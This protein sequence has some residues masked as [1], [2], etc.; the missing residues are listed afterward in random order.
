VTLEEACA[1][2]EK[3]ADGDRHGRL[4]GGSAWAFGDRQPGLALFDD[5]P[6]AARRMR[7]ADARLYDAK[8]AGRNRVTWDD[9]RRA[10]REAAL[11]GPPPPPN[12]KPP[13]AAAARDRGL[14]GGLRVSPADAQEGRHHPMELARER[15]WLR[16][17][18]S[19]FW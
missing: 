6:D 17:C 3:F 4:R 10:G 14:D 18:V 19:V 8:H 16:S 9:R 2:C 7:V 12:A 15:C 13:G 11:R 5:A 1:V